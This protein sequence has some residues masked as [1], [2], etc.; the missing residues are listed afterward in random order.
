MA[1]SRQ[2]KQP[3]Q[4]VT[5]EKI[6]DGAITSDKLSIEGLKDGQ[7]RRLFTMKIKQRRVGGKTF[8]GMEYQGAWNVETKL[9]GPMGQ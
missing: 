9:N 1:L 8:E 6:K 4:I 2:I 7:F 5:N 3:M